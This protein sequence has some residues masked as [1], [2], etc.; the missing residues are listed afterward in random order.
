MLFD[1]KPKLKTK[2]ADDKPN[3]PINNGKLEYLNRSLYVNY[4]LAPRTIDYS[5]WDNLNLSDDEE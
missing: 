4:C 3:S 1:S 2:S 5:K